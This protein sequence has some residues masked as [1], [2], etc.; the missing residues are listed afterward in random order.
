[1]NW[2][3]FTLHRTDQKLPP[4]RKDVLVMV[5]ERRDDDG[6]GLPEAFAVGYRKDD[7]LGPYFVVPGVGG[8]VVAWCDCL[9]SD[10]ELSK[11]LAF[12]RKLLAGD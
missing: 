5:D 4:I 10:F 11:T 8:P 9:P 2:H 1:M 7:S 6:S 12:V 3:K